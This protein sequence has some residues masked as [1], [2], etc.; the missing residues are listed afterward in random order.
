M[1]ACLNEESNIAF[2]Y[3]FPLI[4]KEVSAAPYG[5]QRGAQQYLGSRI[6]LWLDRHS[7]LYLSSIQRQQFQKRL[8]DQILVLRRIHAEVANSNRVDTYDSIK[9]NSN[10]VDNRQMKPNQGP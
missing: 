9:Q 7:A 6:A 4:C 2:L 8:F 3:V 10:R 5:I 1:E